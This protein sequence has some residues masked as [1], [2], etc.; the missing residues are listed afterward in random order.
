MKKTLSLF[1][2]SIFLSSLYFSYAEEQ[3]KV[4]F[5]LII[6]M[7]LTSGI[8]KPIGKEFGKRP[9][10][11]ILL[12]NISDKPQKIWS[13]WCS[14]GYS[15]LSFEL[16]LDGKK[17]IVKKTPIG[18]R[19]NVPA[20]LTILPHEYMVF[21]IYISDEWENFPKVDKKT[22]AEIRV[23]YKIVGDREAKEYGV[24]TGEICSQ[25]LQVTVYP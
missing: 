13:E 11:H 21:D 8:E 3:N 7:P 16:T 25:T 12:K 20:D 10:F 5:E 18:W 6:V 24:W 1:L 9:N 23:R 17:F 4:P 19:R 22:I 2:V 14:W 15:N